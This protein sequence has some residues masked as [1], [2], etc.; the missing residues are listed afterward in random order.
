KDKVIW[1]TGASSGIGEALVHC[2]AEQGAKLILTSRNADKL[3]AVAKN[4]HLTQDQYLIIPMDMS[5]LTQAM[6]TQML[7]KIIEKFDR[8]DMVFLNAGVTQRYNALDNLT[9]EVDRQLMEINFF[10]PILMAKII[11]DHFKQ[12]GGGHIV[13][14]SSIFGKMG[15]PGRTIYCA[16]K[17]ALHGFFDSLRIELS[18]DKVQCSLAVLGAIK[19]QVSF[20]ALTATGEAYNQQGR[21]QTQGYP[22]MR[23]ATKMLRYVTKGTPEFVIGGRELWGLRIRRWLPRLYTRL[24]RKYIVN[25]Q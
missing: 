3:N 12:Q 7:A 6:V 14:T 22:A 2:L 11:A 4:T 17:H 23:C 16:S 10:A 13:V 9:L 19:T 1:V 15:F 21:W 24:A 5:H 18:A 8:L 25:T 20:N